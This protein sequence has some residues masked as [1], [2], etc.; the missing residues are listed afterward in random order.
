MPWASWA[1]V[2]LGCTHRGS[3]R[4]CPG[5]QAGSGTSSSRRPLNPWKRHALI[6]RPSVKGVSQGED[7]LAVTGVHQDA[8]GL[9]A[10]VDP[11][12]RHRLVRAVEEPVRPAPRDAHGVVA[13]DRVLAPGDL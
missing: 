4:T 11:H 8:V 9:V 5:A 12:H 1:S 3:T 7:A 2:T 10:G 13:R 6:A